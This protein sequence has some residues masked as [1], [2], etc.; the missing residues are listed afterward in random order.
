MRFPAA[1]RFPG[2][3]PALPFDAP[4]EAFQILLVVL[5]RFKAGRTLEH[6]YRSPNGSGDLAGPLPRGPHFLGWA[7][8]AVSVR[9]PGRH[10]IL[11][12][13]ICRARRRMRHELP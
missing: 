13:P 3:M 1:A 10:W 4:K 2:D 5:R 12:A 9:L 6:D 7:E 8:E 11:Q